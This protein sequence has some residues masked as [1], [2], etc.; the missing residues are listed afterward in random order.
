MVEGSSAWIRLTARAIVAV[1]LLLV[2]GLLSGCG[3]TPAP[4]AATLPPAPPAPPAAPASTIAPTPPPSLCQDAGAYRGGG[5]YNGGWGRRPG[6]AVTVSRILDAATFQLVDGRRVRLGGVVVREP[7]SCGGQGSVRAAV[8]AARR[9]ASRTR[10][11]AG[12]RR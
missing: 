1:P 10:R 2:L 8:R 4:L 3:T 11:G 7:T 6:E 9:R 5:A 12:S